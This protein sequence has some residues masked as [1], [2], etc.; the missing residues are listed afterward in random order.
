MVEIAFSLALLAITPF[1]HLVV[2]CGSLPTSEGDILSYY[3][4]TASCQECKIFLSL[5]HITNIYIYIYICVYSYLRFNLNC[6]DN[7]LPTKLDQNELLVNC[8]GRQA[9]GSTLSSVEYL[10]T[11]VAKCTQPDNTCSEKN[12]SYT[13]KPYFLHQLIL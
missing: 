12:V 1:I 13:I 7:D 9:N 3:R 5:M 8:N 6:A 10:I 2:G 4:S 11:I